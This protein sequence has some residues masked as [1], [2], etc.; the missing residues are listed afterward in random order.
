M[1]YSNGANNPYKMNMTN[2]SGFN[3]SSKRGGGIPS[4]GV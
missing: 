2:G 4:G 1:V 3:L